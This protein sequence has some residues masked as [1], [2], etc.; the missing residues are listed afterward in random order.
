ML[1]GLVSTLLMA[2][3]TARLT[4]IGWIGN[5]CADSEYAQLS[6]MTDVTDI[7]YQ[8]LPEM[9]RLLDLSSPSP[10]NITNEVNVVGGR[11]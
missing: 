8:D 5:S 3:A 6:C 7:F 1:A 2:C 11:R 9:L 4:S 10:L